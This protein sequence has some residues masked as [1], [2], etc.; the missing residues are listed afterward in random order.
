MVSKRME[1]ALNEQINAEL[2]SSYLYYSMVAYFKS[3]SLDGFAHWMEMQTLEEM[4][5][6][7]KFADYL[8]ERGG[9]V[10]LKAIEAPKTHWETPLEAFKDAL[11]H[12]RKVTARINDLMALAVEEKDF[13]TQNFLQWFISEQVEE[14]ANVGQIVDQLNMIEGSKN[15]IFMLNRELGSRTMPSADS[16]QQ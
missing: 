5:H 8:N 9:R 10:I 12:E 2:F 1:E 3:A 16:D 7:K 11:E 13:A 14:E 6:A 15:G 4:L